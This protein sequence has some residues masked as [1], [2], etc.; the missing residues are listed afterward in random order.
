MTWIII[1]VVLLLLLFLFLHTAASSMGSWRTT[2][3]LMTERFILYQSENDGDAIKSLLR[4]VNERYQNT[5]GPSLA[6]I[7]HNKTLFLD[8][9]TDGHAQRPQ[10][11]V[12]LLVMGCLWI[13]NNA[14]IK[15]LQRQEY[16]P[17]VEQVYGHIQKVKPDYMTVTPSQI[18]A[19]VQ[20]LAELE[21]QR[22]QPGIKGK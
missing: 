21:P 5:N 9:A 6:Y 12:L 20:L 22:C 10:A 16:R 2:A 7:L 11:D 17:I 15:G 18:D 8:R 19:I 1:G 3:T 14:L 4:G 13:E